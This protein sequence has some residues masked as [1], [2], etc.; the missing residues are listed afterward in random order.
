MKCNN[1][2]KSL[3]MCAGLAYAGI[4]YSLP[5]LEQVAN[6]EVNVAYPDVNVMH[7]NQISDKAIVD[8]QSFNISDVEKVNFQQP[9]NSS[10]CLNRINA[11]NGVSEIAGQLNSNGQVLLIN[12]AGVLFSES[13]KVNVSGIVASTVT[14]SEENFANFDNEQMLLDK[15]E[16]NGVIVNAGIMNSDGHVVLF[17]AGVANKGLIHTNE[18]NIIIAAGN[19][20]LVDYQGLGILK[21]A[22]APISEKP[23]DKNGNP[24]STAVD[25]AGKIINDGGEVYLGAKGGDIVFDNLINVSG[26]IQAKTT[27]NENG[28]IELYGDSK[29][30]I[31]VTGNLDVSNNIEK[32][33]AGFVLMA[34]SE[35]IID[36]NAHI[37]ASG[38]DQD[39]NWGGE[40]SVGNGVSV[41]VLEQEIIPN[42]DKLY[43]GPNVI[44]D[45]SSTTNNA[46]ELQISATK[47]IIGEGT[48]RIGSGDNKKPG[49]INIDAM[50]RTT[51]IDVSNLKIYDN[52]SARLSN[53]IIAIDVGAYNLIEQFIK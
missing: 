19:K 41:S 35:I 16:G 27:A 34:S 42:T 46:G 36:E 22:I 25:V 17:G 40:I 29:G 24:V 32:Q 20:L 15:P 3:V 39:F 48:I 44:M 9:T 28:A 30:R 47:D 31:H 14:M 37:N 51:N 38:N 26:E 53:D 49:E 7:V 21:F 6:G 4:A 13:A 50:Q 5:E 18:Q 23:L 12:G 8:W 10:I 11:A 1:F 33:D 43:I 52:N 2:I 45:V